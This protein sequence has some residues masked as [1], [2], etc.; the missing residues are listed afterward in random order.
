MKILVISY[1]N[2]WNT[3]FGTELEL[4]QV[5]LDRGDDVEF[6]GCDRCLV[7]CEGNPTGKTSKCDKCRLRRSGGLS[8]LSRTIREHHLGDYLP[9]EAIV[10]EAAIKETIRD[11]ETAE[12]FT[13]AG[14]DFGDG[15]LSSAI[16]SSRDPFC[17]TEA[18]MEILRNY[19]R[20]AVRSYLAVREFLRKHPEFNRVYVFNGRF[21]S[22]RGALRACQEAEGVEVVTHERGANIG[23]Y[24]LFLNAMPHDRMLWVSETERAWAAAPSLEVAK[25]I[26]SAFFR[27]RKIGANTEWYSFI[28][29][30]ET[31]KLPAGWDPARKNVVIFNSSEDEFVGMGDE[32]KNPIY[33]F[34]ADGIRR[35]VDDAINRYPDIMFYIRVHPNLTGVNNRD[36]GL[37]GDL[38]NSGRRNVV[39]IEPDSVISSYS[40]LDAAHQVITFGSTMG[41]EATFWGKP[42]ILAG[43]SFYEDM[44]AAYQVGSH[45]ELMDLVGSDIEPKPQIHA[46]RYGY[47]TK[48]FGEDFKYWKATDYSTGTFKGQS[49]KCEPSSMLVR[50]LM[51]A[52][53]DFRK[54]G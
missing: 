2:S 28:E 47:Y 32:W 50:R 43:R 16:W 13:L 52:Y 49:L 35:I 18:T 40:L 12:K 22:T 39:V 19:A 29:K 11:A 5:H 20:S 26:G 33:K 27:D 3:H 8:L 4:A 7:V 41:V 38:K 9:A 44:D 17:E 45:E 42:S 1:F 14:H 30:Q 23:K 53:R 31:G 36:T 46:I 51:V 15:A 37:I 24:G 21:A 25:E 6:L 54:R 48:T 10:A 34:Q